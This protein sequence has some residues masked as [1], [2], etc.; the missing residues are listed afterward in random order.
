MNIPERTVRHP[1]KLVIT[2]LHWIVH[3]CM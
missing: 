3:I 1:T 2:K